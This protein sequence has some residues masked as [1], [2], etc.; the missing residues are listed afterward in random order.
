MAEYR[1]ISGKDFIKAKPTGQIDLQ[2]S[3]KVLASIAS[4]TKPPADYEILLDIRD[5]NHNGN[6]KKLINHFEILEFVKE[7]VRNRSAFRN[8]IAV[9]SRDGRQLDNS[10]FM[11]LCATNRGL[12]VKAFTSLE[13]SIQWLTTPIEA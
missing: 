13:D 2:E 1:V 4:I 11:E 5:V 7:L 10:R 9:L 6:A 8:K 12:N 3:K